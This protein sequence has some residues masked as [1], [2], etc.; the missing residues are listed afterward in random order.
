VLNPSFEATQP[1]QHRDMGERAASS[2]N[3]P[4]YRE[5]LASRP[6]IDGLYPPPDIHGRRL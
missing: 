4:T 5:I 6:F 3:S 2:S 1:E